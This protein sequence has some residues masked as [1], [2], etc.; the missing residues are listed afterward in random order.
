MASDHEPRAGAVLRRPNR[1]EQRNPGLVTLGG[2]V[3]NWR[4]CAILG[5]TAAEVLAVRGPSGS[6]ATVQNKIKVTRREMRNEGWAFPVNPERASDPQA[7]PFLR[8][9]PPASAA[10]CDADHAEREIQQAESAWASE[11]AARQLRSGWGM[12]LRPGKAAGN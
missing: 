2:S 12:R 9:I 6:K 4:Q 7:R 3:T 5:L 1:T 8:A 11:Q 10:L